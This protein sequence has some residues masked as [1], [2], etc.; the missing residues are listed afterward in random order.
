VLRG[1]RKAAVSRSIGPVR[2]TNSS[3]D[4]ET[5]KSIMGV[6]KAD[7]IKI[8][9]ISCEYLEEGGVLV[10]SAETTAPPTSALPKSKQRNSP[11]DSFFARVPQ[12]SNKKGNDTTG[13]CADDHIKGIGDICSVP[14]RLHHCTY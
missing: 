8:C 3:N 1:K 13:G 5:Y 10:D 4:P 2:P 11:F 12:Q 14:N 7:L 9:L 6:L